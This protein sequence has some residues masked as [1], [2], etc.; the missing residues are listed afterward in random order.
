M[1]VGLIRRSV[2]VVL[3]VSIFSLICSTYAIFFPSMLPTSLFSEVLSMIGLFF[4]VFLVPMLAG[5]SMQTLGMRLMKIALVDIK[6][7]FPKWIFLLKYHALWLMIGWVFPFA[8][9]N[10]KRRTIYDWAA[11]ASYVHCAKKPVG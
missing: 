5:D 1:V 7:Q 3:D 10:K 9:I 8:F 4:V 6:Q 2:A 11:G